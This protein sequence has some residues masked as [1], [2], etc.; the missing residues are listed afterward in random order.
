MCV[1]LLPALFLFSMHSPQG[2]SKLFSCKC[3]VHMKEFSCFCALFISTFSIFEIVC[4]H[5]NTNYVSL[6]SRS[7]IINVRKRACGQFCLDD[8]VVRVPPL[9]LPPPNKKKKNSEV[10]ESWTHHRV[11]STY[12][13]VCFGVLKFTSCSS[14]VGQLAGS[15]QTGQTPHRPLLHWH[16]LHK[17]DLEGRWQ[18][19]TQKHTCKLLTWKKNPWGLFLKIFFSS[20]NLCRFCCMSREAHKS[21]HQFS[22]QKCDSFDDKSACSYNNESRILEGSGK[23]PCVVSK[24]TFP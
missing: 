22:D 16:S 8:C 9:A 15:G 3:F 12:K 4:N 23:A 2:K 14:N 13:W 19:E 6:S 17:R 21:Q 20:T 11:H 1:V 7:S 24:G 18:M 5:K 10:H